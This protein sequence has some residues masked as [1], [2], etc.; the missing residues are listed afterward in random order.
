[1]LVFNCTADA[2][3]VSGLLTSSTV[4][5]TET[6]SNDV[7]KNWASA[8]SASATATDDKGMSVRLPLC[9]KLHLKDGRANE[10]TDRRQK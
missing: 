6:P 5:K 1:M 9:V 8:N 7:T 3:F 2:S 4:V 10:R